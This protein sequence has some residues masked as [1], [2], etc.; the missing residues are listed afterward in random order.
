MNLLKGNFKWIYSRAYIGLITPPCTRTRIIIFKIN[1]KLEKI[2]KNQVDFVKISCKFS[3]IQSNFERFFK[4]SANIPAPKC[5]LP[6]PD[7]DLAS[8]SGLPIFGIGI[9]FGISR[10]R[11]SRIY[12]SWKGWRDGAIFVVR[13]RC[14]L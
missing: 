11:P 1:A 5:P 14:V 6:N 10:S 4:I 3:Q 13:N 8:G 12:P 2:L 7:R 9:P